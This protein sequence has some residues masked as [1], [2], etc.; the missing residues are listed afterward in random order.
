[1]KNFTWVLIVVLLSTTIQSCRVKPNK[2]YVRVSPAKTESGKMEACDVTIQYSSPF[3]KG[4]TVY[5]ELVPYDGVW[6]AGANEATTIEFSKAVKIDGK[7]LAAGKYTFFVIPKK[8]GNW[9]IIFN[10]KLN[11]WGAFAY[12][13]K[14]NV[15]VG[16][17]KTATIDHVESLKYWMNANS[18]FLDWASTRMSFEVGAE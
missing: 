8:E 13:E 14:H 9:S 3:V 15:L 12:N 18:I 2:N 7:V 11:Q 17:A 10:K 6:R 4:R 1:M 5:G 16:S